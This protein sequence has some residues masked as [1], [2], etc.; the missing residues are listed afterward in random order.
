MANYQLGPVIGKIGGADAEKIPVD[1]VAGG[2]DGSR[3]VMHTVD[4]PEGE[5]WFVVLSGNLTPMSTGGNGPQLS[6]G[7]VSI[8]PN[9]RSGHTSMVA[10]VT[11]TAEITLKRNASAN[12]DQFSGHVYTAPL[13]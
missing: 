9:L 4:V 12:Q 8:G 11:G 5:T 3:V 10:K 6:I 1:I 13:P 2:G 7:E